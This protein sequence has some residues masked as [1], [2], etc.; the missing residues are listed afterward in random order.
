MLCLNN[1]ERRN[2]TSDKLK[3]GSPA[4]KKGE[5]NEINRLG[6]RTGLSATI[7]EKGD[8]LPPTQKKSRKWEKKN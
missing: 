7:K 2:L 1:S 8:T 3:P 4:P 5:Y 6:N